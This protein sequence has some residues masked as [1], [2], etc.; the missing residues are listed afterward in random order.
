[1]ESPSIFMRMVAIVHVS[2]STSTTTGTA[3]QYSTAAPVLRSQRTIRLWPLRET[4]SKNVFKS[5]GRESAGERWGPSCLRKR[6]ERRDDDF[7]SDPNTSAQQGTVQ[8]RGTVGVQD[9][10]LVVEAR[11]EALLQLGG[12]PERP[13]VVDA[14]VQHG[15][16]VLEGALGLPYAWQRDGALVDLLVGPHGDTKGLAAGLRDRGAEPAA[17]RGRLGLLTVQ[18]SDGR[19]AAAED[20]AGDE[21]AGE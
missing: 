11:A 10:V 1:M 9:A 21:A 3:L 4:S 2:G 8:G 19:D 6:R 20:E 14:V 16:G 13:R 15:S 5:V 18:E 17:L 12:V 7:V